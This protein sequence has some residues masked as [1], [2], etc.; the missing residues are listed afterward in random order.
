[1]VH[2]VLPLKKMSVSEKLEVIERVWSSLRTDDA[3][4]DSPAWHGPLLEERR[5]LHADGKAK[6]VDWTEAKKRTQRKVRAR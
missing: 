2:V 1:M 5:R 4:L 6:F 3:Q